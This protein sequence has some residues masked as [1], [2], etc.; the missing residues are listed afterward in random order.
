METTLHRTSSA[1]K[2]TKTSVLDNGSTTTLTSTSWV[3]V[4]P[5]EKTGD[6]D[7]DPSLQ[8]DGPSVR[9]AAGPAM[10]IGG[11]VAGLLMV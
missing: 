11:L 2:E 7:A 5:P 6:D 9:A 1:V 3:E 10:M 4:D 8:D